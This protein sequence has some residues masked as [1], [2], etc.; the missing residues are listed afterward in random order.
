MEVATDEASTPIKQDTKKGKLRDYPCVL[1]PCWGHL[2]P[3]D[4]RNQL[5]MQGLHTPMR[6]HSDVATHTLRSQ[7]TGLEADRSPEARMHAMTQVQ[8]QLELRHAAPD[9]GGTLR[10]AYTLP[11]LVFDVEAR[12]ESS[13]VDVA[14]PGTQ[15]PR[16]GE[17]GG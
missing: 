12:A 16:R 13:C 6:R 1:A 9:V 3:P 2:E 14:G 4:S 5:W 10:A 17:H 7:C 15:E 8:H 11:R